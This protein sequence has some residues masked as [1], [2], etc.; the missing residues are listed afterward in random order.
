MIAK[1]SKRIISTQNLTRRIGTHGYQLIDEDEIFS[2]QPFDDM[3]MQPCDMY[4][5]ILDPMYVDLTTYLKRDNLYSW[6]FKN[7]NIKNLIRSK[8]YD[9]RLPYLGEEDDEE[10]EAWLQESIL[11]TYKEEQEPDYENPYMK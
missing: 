9:M 8:S 7:K 6:V 5:V 10:Q 2:V 11:F 3:S 1:Q 4:D